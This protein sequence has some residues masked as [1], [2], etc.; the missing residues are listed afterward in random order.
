MGTDAARMRRLRARKR[1]GKVV[2][3]IEIDPRALA[4][5]LRE[6]FP[7]ADYTKADFPEAT[8]KLLQQIA[9]EQDR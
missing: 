9:Q 4:A 6:V 5:T 8:A 7:E 2:L 1:A 3:A